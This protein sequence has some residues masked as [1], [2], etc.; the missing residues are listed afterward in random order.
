MNSIIADNNL[1]AIF[2]YIDDVIICDNNKEEHDKNLLNFKKIAKKFNI[3]LNEAKC[4]YSLKEINYLGYTI[5]NG[6]L[7][8][9]TDR[10]K[11]F[12]PL[13]MLPPCDVL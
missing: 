6:S 12:L 5:A 7:R 2:V 1:S 11:P 10:L 13:G 9:D 4:L 8:P 3:S